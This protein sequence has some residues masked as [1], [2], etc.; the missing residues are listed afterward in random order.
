QSVSNVS[1]IKWGILALEGAIW[2]GFSPAEMATP[3]L[4]LIGVGVACFAL[5]VRRLARRV[6]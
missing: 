6:G 1:P 2:R 4:I 3:C 5:G